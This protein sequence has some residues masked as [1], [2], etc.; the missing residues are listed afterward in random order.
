LAGLKTGKVS[1]AWTINWHEAAIQLGLNNRFATAY[2]QVEEEAK[3][4]IALRGII[5]IG[6]IV[7]YI[8]T[9]ISEEKAIDALTSQRERHFEAIV[10]L[11]AMQSWEC[12]FPSVF[13][14]TPTA[15]AVLDQLNHAYPDLKLERSNTVFAEVYDKTVK[16]ARDRVAQA[17]SVSIFRIIEDW[18]DEILK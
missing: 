7:D 6:E 9:I 13:Q 12:A 2:G 18:R 4:R 14:D 8:S 5:T 3:V 15:Q 1:F 16:R 10:Y 17:G 11:R